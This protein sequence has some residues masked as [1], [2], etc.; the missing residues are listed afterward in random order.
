MTTWL[1]NRM[2]EFRER[3]A[4]IWHDREIR[5]ADLLDS[6]QE[7]RVQLAEAGIERGECVAMIG[8]CSPGMS[9]LLLALVLNG[10]IIVPLGPMER[11]PRDRF[12]ETARAQGAFEF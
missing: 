10:N 6:I 12:L 7:W 4:L 2:D 5:Y 9:S 3:P 1:W 11:Q 8:E